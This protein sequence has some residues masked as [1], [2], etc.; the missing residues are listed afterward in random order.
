MNTNLI[1]DGL[2]RPVCATGPNNETTVAVYDSLG[3]TVNTGGPALNVAC[4]TTTPSA[5][6]SLTSF[7]YD[8]LSRPTSVTTADGLS[9]TSSYSQNL[10]TTT[11]QAGNKR[12]YTTDG[13]GG[14]TQVLE[15][16]NNA[17][18]PSSSTSQIYTTY[19]YT[20]LDQLDAVHQP[21]SPG[22]SCSPSSSTPGHTYIS[23]NTGQTRLFTYDSLE[24]TQLRIVF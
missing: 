20:T 9:A 18:V 24:P 12:Q 6:A 19:C 4:P 3:R 13:L 11:D 8:G 14:L 15:N 7:A 2:R 10:T 21:T 22:T 1:Y 23:G 16:S 17:A 5:P